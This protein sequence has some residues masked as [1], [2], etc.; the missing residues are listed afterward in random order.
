M[1][2]IWER[3]VLPMKHVGPH[4]LCSLLRSVIKLHKQ[5]VLCCTFS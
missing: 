5:R 1:S 4:L 3:Q 2:G